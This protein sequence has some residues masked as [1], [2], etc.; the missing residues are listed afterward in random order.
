MKSVAVCSWVDHDK[1]AQT[2]PPKLR[3]PTQQWVQGL[4]GA[5]YLSYF[6]DHSW[7]KWQEI[8]FT[9]IRVKHVAVEKVQAWKSTRED[10]KMRTKITEAYKK[11]HHKSM[12]S[13]NSMKTVMPVLTGPPSRK[14]T[15][16]HPRTGVCNEMQ[17]GSLGRLQQR[18]LEMCQFD[19][20]R[21]I[22]RQVRFLALHGDNLVIA[23]LLVTYQRVSTVDLL[24]A[25][26]G[27]LHLNPLFP[28]TILLL[29]C[30]ID[31]KVVG[32][33]AN[34]RLSA[35]M[36][37][38]KVVTGPC[39]VGNFTDGVHSHGGTPIAG[40]FIMETPNL[41][42][43]MTEFPYLNPHNHIYSWNGTP[44]DLLLRW[45]YANFGKIA[46]QTKTTA[47]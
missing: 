37:Y 5:W 38:P 7:G 45:W 30:P 40:W 14:S 43:M 46:E 20:I 1:P 34:L 27:W 17:R 21:I 41:K 22:I 6:S 16:C 33:I 12:A 29:T 32:C 39:W 13:W 44:K 10:I 42:W 18:W 26:A 4:E 2:G 9:R 15:L 23:S 24:F 25:L 11:G 8:L 28:L 36:V 19:S 3:L 31:L 47:G 35:K